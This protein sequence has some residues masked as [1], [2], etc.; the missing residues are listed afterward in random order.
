MHGTAAAADVGWVLLW[1]AALV[2]VF[3]PVAMRLYRAER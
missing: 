1:S 2:V 3:A